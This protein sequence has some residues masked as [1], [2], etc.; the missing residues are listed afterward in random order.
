MM[1]T[2]GEHGHEDN[3]YPL[4]GGS[5]SNAGHHHSLFFLLLPFSWMM[6]SVS[7]NGENT[8]NVDAI[9]NQKLVEEVNEFKVENVFT[10]ENDGFWWER[11]CLV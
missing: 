5:V 11:S 9:S 1:R 8:E 4:S 10:T 3:D 6:V 2:R 7:F